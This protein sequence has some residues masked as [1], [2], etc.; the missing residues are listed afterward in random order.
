M[1][2]NIFFNLTFRCKSYQRSHLA[3]SQQAVTIFDISL[4]FFL[5]IA[6]GF[7]LILASAASSSLMQAAA[8]RVSLWIRLRCRPK[9][10]LWVKTWPHIWHLNGFY[11]VCLRKWSFK[12]HPFLKTARQPS[13]LQ[14]KIILVR[15]VARLGTDMVRCQVLGTPERTLLGEDFKGDS[16]YIVSAG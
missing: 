16:I 8:D 5:N 10:P 15:L 7:D 14:K 4:L 6:L 1:Q 12:L 2:N 11:S 3:V 9:F 13:N